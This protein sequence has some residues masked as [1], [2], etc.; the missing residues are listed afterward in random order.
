MKVKI[1]LDLDFIEIFELKIIIR[2][3][4]IKVM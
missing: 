4:L 1:F 2:C 3:D